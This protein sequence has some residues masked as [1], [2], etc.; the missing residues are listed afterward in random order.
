L[1]FSDFFYGGGFAGGTP[2]PSCIPAA[3]PPAQPIGVPGG[4]AT[5]FTS[6]YRKSSPS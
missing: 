6:W 2:P 4:P 5:T 1:S 3:P